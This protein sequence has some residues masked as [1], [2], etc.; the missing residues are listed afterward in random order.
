MGFTLPQHFCYP[1]QR[2]RTAQMQPVPHQ[3]YLDPSLPSSETRRLSFC[4]SIFWIRR[5]VL[6]FLYLLPGDGSLGG[7]IWELYSHKWVAYVRT[8]EKNAVFPIIGEKGGKSYSS[9]KINMAFFGGKK[10]FLQGSCQLIL[11]YCIS[12]LHEK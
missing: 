5:N 9:L 4:F 8:G 6:T 11:L 10:I 7:S 1:G 3:T 12:W 2:A